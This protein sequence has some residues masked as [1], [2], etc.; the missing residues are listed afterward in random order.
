MGFKDAE[1]A[2][3]LDLQSGPKVVLVAICH[4]VDDRTHQTHVGRKSI[5]GMVGMTLRAV[6]KQLGVLEDLGIITREE[7][8]RA[9]GYRATDIITANVMWNPAQVNNDQVNIVHVNKV[10]GNDVPTSGERGSDLRGTTFQASR[11]KD[12]LGQSTGQSL[13]TETP[14]DRFDEAYAHWPKKEKRKDAF[15]RFVRAARSRGIDQLVADIIRFGDAYA[16][17]V[18][19]QFV[20]ALGVWINGA[21]WDD[22]LPQPREIRTQDRA[23]TRN[24]RNL[25]LVADIARQTASTQRG[26]SA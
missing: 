8:R 7:R 20:P 3:G 12:L 15:E 4:R 10:Q 21:R 16:A 14:A 2:Y 9:D 18:P 23:P 26:I 25:A 1:W 17:H 11:S 19:R 24:E 5:A 13:V 22:D 6:S